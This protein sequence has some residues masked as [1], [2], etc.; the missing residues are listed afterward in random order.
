MDPRELRSG[1]TGKGEGGAGLGAKARVVGSGEEVQVLS[2]GPGKPSA[3]LSL[4]NG[5]SGG[6]GH[7]LRLCETL[8]SG[9]L[10]QSPHCKRQSLL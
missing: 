6:L 9:I 10:G 2:W 3:S 5:D 7:F 8:G 1:R 4:L